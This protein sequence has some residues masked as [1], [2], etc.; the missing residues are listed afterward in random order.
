MALG[1]FPKAIAEIQNAERVDPLSHQVQAIFGRILSGDGKPEEA[2]VHLM[3]AIEREPRSA[4]AHA[5]LGQVYEQLDRYSEALAS[6]DRARVLRGNPP[7]FPPFLER[8]AHV[9]A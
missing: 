4:M 3:Q 7:D 2:I 9:Y 1:R 6:Y 8:L 5:F